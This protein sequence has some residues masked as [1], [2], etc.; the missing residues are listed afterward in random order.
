MAPPSDKQDTRQRGRSDDSPR[1]SRSDTLRKRDRNSRS[2]V[3]GNGKGTSGNASLR[4]SRSSVD[5]KDRRRSRSRL[6][7]IHFFTVD[8]SLS[9][10]I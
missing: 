7:G 3:T 2:P 4:Q 8:I 9:N 1:K 10:R 6:D 5:G